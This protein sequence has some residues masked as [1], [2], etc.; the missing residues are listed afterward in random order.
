MSVTPTG[1][2]TVAKRLNENAL[3]SIVI[4]VDGITYIKRN[5]QCIIT[6]KKADIHFTIQGFTQYILGVRSLLQLQFTL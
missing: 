4:N 5:N 6:S 2:F 3:A 1:I